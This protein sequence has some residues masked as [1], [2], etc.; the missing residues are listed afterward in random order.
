MVRYNL[1]EETNSQTFWN[2]LKNA[3]L[4]VLIVIPANVHEKLTY[5]EE[6]SNAATSEYRDHALGWEWG[7]GS[8]IRHT[9]C[10]CV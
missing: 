9:S 1:V 10:H 6:N 8:C 7:E 3:N 2:I 4:A 5:P